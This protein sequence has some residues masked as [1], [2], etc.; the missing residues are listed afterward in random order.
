MGAIRN[1]TK[2]DI[3]V[4]TEAGAFA[5][6]AGGPARDLAPERVAEIEKAGAVYFAAGEL[7]TVASKKDAEDAA[8]AKA[9]AEAAAKA[10][11]D[12]EDAAAAKAAKK[13]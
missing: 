5:F 6:P 1:T 12:A 9:K 4:H 2:G 11:A 10:K 7:V 8:A 3:T 13:K